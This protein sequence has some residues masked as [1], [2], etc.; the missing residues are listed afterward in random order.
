MNIP[1]ATI[2]ELIE[3]S[4]QS[5][6]FRQIDDWMQKTFP[7]LERRLIKSPTITLAAYGRL[8]HISENEIYSALISMAPQKNNLS[9]YVAGEKKGQPILQ[10][11]RPFFAPSNM[12][13]SCLRIKNSS[14]LKTDILEKIILDAIEWNK[15]GISLGT[16]S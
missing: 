4:N 3:Q 15:N 5:E 9:L 8:S 14:Q 12:G 7:E 16:S 1:A 10:H 11:Y 13:K 2:E 6:V